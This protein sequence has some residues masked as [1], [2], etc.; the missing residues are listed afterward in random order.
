MLVSQ[1]DSNPVDVP[2]LAYLERLEQV[3]VLLARAGELLPQLAQLTLQ[4]STHEPMRPVHLL[5]E[6]LLDQVPTA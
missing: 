6:V 4:T 1:L 5:D 3:L 2:R